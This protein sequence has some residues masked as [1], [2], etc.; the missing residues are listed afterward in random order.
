VTRN[1]NPKEKPIMGGNAAN[2]SVWAE[3]DVYIAPLGTAIPASVTTPF[4]AGWLQVG[5][6]DG[7]D[8]FEESRSED[9]KDLFAWG[10]LL[11]ATPRKNF[12]LTKKFSA[13]EDNTTTR[14]LIW[15][16][17]TSAVLSVPKPANIMI[18]FETRSGGKVKRVISR[19]YVQVDLDGSIKDG[20]EDLT[21]AT[22]VATIFPDAS[23][24]LF[25][26]QYTPDVVSLAITPLTLA[27]SLAGANVKPLVLTATYTDATTGVV[28]SQAAWS[29]SAPAK[30]TTDG[31][32]VTGVAVG[33]ANV[34]A[35]YGGVTAAAP[36][37]VT[38]AA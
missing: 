2:A 13:L 9:K 3:A 7:G 8:G 28:S 24:V 31:R 30:A 16:G 14:S 1:N 25:D 5:L 18:A 4:G 26:R 32:Y 35:S 33:T 37:V 19:N 27:L 6:L 12:K 11:V 15:P 29:S 23:G 22:L 20:E 38:V 34:T 21:K 36:C 17:S 10:G